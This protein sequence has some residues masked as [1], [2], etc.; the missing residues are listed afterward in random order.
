MDSDI[1]L[2]QIWFECCTQLKRSCEI[3]YQDSQTYFNAFTDIKGWDLLLI[4]NIRIIN[5]FGRQVKP[6]VLAVIPLLGILVPANILT[7]GLILKSAFSLYSTTSIYTSNK[8]PDQPILWCPWCH[9][10]KFV[11][12][13]ET[14]TSQQPKFVLVSF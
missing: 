10:Y 14:C 6:S 12:E 3:G 9:I 4:I 2:D 5:I 8:R 1:S 7:A 11:R 13:S